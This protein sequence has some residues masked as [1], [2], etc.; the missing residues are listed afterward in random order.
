M[1]TRLADLLT[2]PPTRSPAEGMREALQLHEDGVAL[3]RQRLVRCGV[4][5]GEL[6]ARIQAWLAETP[7]PGAG[8]P[9]FRWVRLVP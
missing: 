9:G 1:T 6:D 3:E 7:P 2:K 4:P 8:V 5:E